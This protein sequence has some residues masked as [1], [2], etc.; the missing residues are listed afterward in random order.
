M[1]KN[2]PARDRALGSDLVARKR[3]VDGLP[4]DFRRHQNGRHG[5]SL[6]EVT[7]H[8]ASS[9]REGK[10]RRIVSGVCVSF[11]NTAVN[12]AGDVRCRG[13]TGQFFAPPIRDN[14]GHVRHTDV[15]RA[16]SE[17]QLRNQGL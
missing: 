7:Y 1:I 8:E 13:V 5:G 12:M 3:F 9:L 4:A 10:R 15:I 11:R 2:A 17:R 16:G 14:V 6:A